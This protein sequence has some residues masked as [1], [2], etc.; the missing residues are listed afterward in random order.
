MIYVP[1]RGVHY[2]NRMPLRAKLAK[3]IELRGG[4]SLKGEDIQVRPDDRKMGEF[5]RALRGFQGGGEVI[6]RGG[7]GGFACLVV[8][9]RTDGT[10]RRYSAVMKASDLSL[11]RGRGLMG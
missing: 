10:D 8:L 3:E 6:I 2:A 7:L 11:F 9:E 4:F 5:M 1:D